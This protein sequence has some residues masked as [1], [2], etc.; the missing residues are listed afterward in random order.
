MLNNNNNSVLPCTG[1][2]L[3]LLRSSNGEELPAMQES[4]V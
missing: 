3:E 4:S 1:N 2:T